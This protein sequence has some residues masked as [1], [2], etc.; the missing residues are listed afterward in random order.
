MLYYKHVCTAG[1]LGSKRNSTLDHFGEI[2]FKMMQKIDFHCPHISQTKLIP[3]CTVTL[4]SSLN[5]LLLFSELI[6]AW[7]FV[8]SEFTHSFLLFV[9]IS[10]CL[11]T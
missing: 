4:I 8:L 10:L 11:P 1:C 6:L 9:P 3:T 2:F 7:H 5:L